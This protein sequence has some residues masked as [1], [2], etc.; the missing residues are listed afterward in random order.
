MTSDTHPA[1][2]SPEPVGSY[3]PARV[4]GN[5]LFIS[6][7]GPRQR[8]E[9]HIPGVVLAPDGSVQSYDIEAQ[10]H[11][12]FRNIRYILEEHGSS[13]EKL[14]DMTCFLTDL[15]RDF[16]IYNRVYAEYFPAEKPRP[17]RT[18]VGISKLPQGGGAPINFEVKAIAT[19]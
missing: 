16:A 13:W 4:V 12:V 1:T 5:L 14:V 6:G 17:C 3:P 7:Q 2:R 8:G 9:K 19:L 18:T 11:A 15:E 10:V